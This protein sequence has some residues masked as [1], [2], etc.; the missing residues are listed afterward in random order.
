[1]KIFSSKKRVAAIGI[2]T[3]ATLVG[4]GV[5]VRVLDVDRQRHRL[6]RPLATAAALVTVTRTTRVQ[7]LSQVTRSQPLDSL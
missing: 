4:G 7:P 3:A 2:V 6:P 5:G 1:M